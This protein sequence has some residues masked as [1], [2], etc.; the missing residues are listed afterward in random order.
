MILLLRVS[1]PFGSLA[2]QPAVCIDAF[3]QISLQHDIPTG[4]SVALESEEVAGIFGS[5]FS[6]DR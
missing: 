2:N 1:E 6:C 4:I 3:Q 5:F